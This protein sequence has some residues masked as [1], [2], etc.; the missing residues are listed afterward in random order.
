MKSTLLSIII[1]I[2]TINSYSQTIIVKDSLQSKNSFT[3][4]ILEGGGSLIGADI[5]ILLIKKFGIQFGAG[6]VGY[7]AGFTFHLKP[8]IR[9]SFI[10]V[11]YWHQGIGRS[12]TQS[13]VSAN[14]V[15][16]GKKW[17]TFQI[18]L[19]ATLDKGP[20]WPKETKQLPVILTYAIGGYTPI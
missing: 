7:G 8:S 16:R 2:F 12:F 15:Y 11:Q 10:S 18:G 9:S 19:G 1:T 3:I 4:G 5:E 20:V 14:F 17:F 13:V 6:L